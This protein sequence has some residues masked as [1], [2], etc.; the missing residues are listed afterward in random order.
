MSFPSEGGLSVRGPEESQ[1]LVETDGKPGGSRGPHCL[2]SAGHQGVIIVEIGHVTS[3]DLDTI[4]T[5]ARLQ[6]EASRI[7]SSIR[8]NH[9]SPTLRALLALVGLGEVVPCCADSDLGSERQAEERKQPVGVEE[10][11]EPCDQTRRDFEDLQ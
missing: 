9:A 7:G 6:L 3:P 5:L 1:P 2:P 8:L 4:E 10:E 11:V